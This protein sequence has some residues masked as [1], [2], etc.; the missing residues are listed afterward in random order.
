MQM[1]HGATFEARLGKLEIRAAADPVLI[2]AIGALVAGILL[3]IPPI[4]RAAKER[5]ARLAPGR[6]HQP[7]S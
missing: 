6:D 2:L 5:P 3:S 7:E 1:S 4:I